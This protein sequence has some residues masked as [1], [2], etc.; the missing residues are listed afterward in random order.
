MLNKKSLKIILEKI[1]KTNILVI[2]DS[3][4]DNYI[5]GNV[6]RISPEAPIPIMKIEENFFIPGGAGNVA[7][8]LSK[9]GIKSYFISLVGKDDAGKKL[10][11]LLKLSKNIKTN[12]VIDEFRKTSIKTR[13]IGNSQQL[14]RTDE[15]TT[16]K[17]S[18][19]VEKQIFQCYVK[20]IKNSDVVIISDYGKGIFLGNF[21]QRIIKLALDLKK[22]VIVDPK[23]N[24]FSQYKGAYCIT[25]NIKEAYL[26][27][28]VNVRDNY[29]AEKCGLYIIEKNWSKT[30]LLTRGKEGLSIIEKSNQTHF[31]ADTEE[32]YDVSGA[33]DTVVAFF[34][35]AIAAKLD[36]HTAAELANLA[37]GIVVKKSGAATVNIEEMLLASKKKYGNKFKNKHFDRVSIKQKISEWKINNLNIGFT[38]GCFD[39]LHSGHIET[40]KQASSV[41]DKLIVGINSDS[42]IR[43]I[44]GEKRPIQD[45]KSRLSIVSSLSMIDAVV[46]FNENTPLKLIKLIKPDFLIK[47][48]DYKTSEIV[49][50]S[51]ISKWGG[52]IVRT[53]LVKNRSTTKLIEL[54]NKNIK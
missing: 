3:M 22:N 16:S 12:I 15:E 34:A 2:G 45:E 40:L 38:N 32:V 5:I 4:L 25:P 18:R 43:K 31:K 53:K 20:A 51:T 11:K 19:E 7:L 54:I 29:T 23:N 49:G 26:A 8:N 37:A 42:S 47:G 28:N 41:C 21:C 46:L 10:I 44:K 1:A 50:A 39:L 13:Y 30:V 14:L 9:F 48:E 35:S 6:E 24:D 33:G 52:K 36:T 27:T 17:M